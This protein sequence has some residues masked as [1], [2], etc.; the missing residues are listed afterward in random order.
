MFFLVQ[1]EVRNQNLAFNLSIQLSIALIAAAAL[2]SGV[3]FFLFIIPLSKIEKYTQELG[4]E[5]LNVD[6]DEKLLPGGLGAIASNLKAIG[7]KHQNLLTEFKEL[8]KKN[9][10][11]VSR[12]NNLLKAISDVGKATTSF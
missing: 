3:I 1:R 8:A 4:S 11:E 2:A 12:R 7:Q 10:L 9:E 5:K 6:L